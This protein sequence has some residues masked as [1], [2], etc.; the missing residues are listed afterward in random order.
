MHNYEEK[1]VY[2]IKLPFVTQSSVTTQQ[3]EVSVSW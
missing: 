1:S 3:N 2:W